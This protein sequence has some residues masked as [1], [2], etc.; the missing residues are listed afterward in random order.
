VVKEWLFILRPHVFV[1]QRKN[2]F[3]DTLS[4]AAVEPYSMHNGDAFSHFAA[5]C[6][7][8]VVLLCIVNDAPTYKLNFRLMGEAGVLTSHDGNTQNSTI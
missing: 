5:C 3:A 8:E 4:P 6:V 7:A 2:L 1:L